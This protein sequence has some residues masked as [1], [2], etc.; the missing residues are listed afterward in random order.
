MKAIKFLSMMLCLVVSMSFASC[1]DDDKDKDEPGG[2]SVSIVGVWRCDY[3]GGS[4]YEYYEFK[5]NGI[6]D[7]W[8]YYG[9]SFSYSGT[10]EKKGSQLI[11]DEDEFY[12]ISS[13][14][15]TQLILTD[16][17]G[18]RYTYYREED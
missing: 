3:D 4:G 11:L 2:A 15:K 7:N 8:G 1:S 16:E 12:T 17:Y 6:Y 14:T 13:L 18:D 5:S 10:Y 9:N